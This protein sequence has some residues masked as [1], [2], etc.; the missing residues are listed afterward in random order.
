MTAIKIKAPS[1]QT[2]CA[3]IP[4]GPAP[5]RLAKAT[6]RPGRRGAGRSRWWW[7]PREVTRGGVG[8]VVL[9]RWCYVGHMWRAWSRI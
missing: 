5:G 9:A 6:P 7:W 4:A 1:L 3:E 8:C 2:H